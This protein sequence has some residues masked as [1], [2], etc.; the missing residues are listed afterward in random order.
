MG[1]TDE[2]SF[3]DADGRLWTW[4][5]VCPFCDR[6]LATQRLVDDEM[7]LSPDDVIGC[8]GCGSDVS[9]ET[10]E[11]VMIDSDGNRA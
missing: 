2:R 11:L 1:Q 10:A 6:E 4:V 7:N 8:D 3:R 5:Y 9:V